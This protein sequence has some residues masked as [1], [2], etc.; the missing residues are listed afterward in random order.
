[1]GRWGL[2]DVST[3]LRFRANCLTIALKFEILDRLPFHFVIHSF[4]VQTLFSFM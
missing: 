4:G 2:E 1:M 3:F